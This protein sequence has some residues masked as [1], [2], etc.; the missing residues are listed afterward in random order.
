LFL[1]SI[2]R[3]LPERFVDHVAAFQ[4]FEDDRVFRSVEV[5][6]AESLAILLSAWWVDYSMN[7][8]A[9]DMLTDGY[10]NTRIKRTLAFVRYQR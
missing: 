1:L 6:Y 7:V 3:V 8:T 2:F 5:D 9:E 10:I 4:H